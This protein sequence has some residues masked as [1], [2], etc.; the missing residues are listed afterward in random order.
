MQI[1]GSG[2]GGWSR[3]WGDEVGSPHVTLI[4]RHERRSIVFSILS[5][6]ARKIENMLCCAVRY[7]VIIQLLSD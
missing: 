2:V 4:R 7:P 6:E 5:L 3:N 1:N